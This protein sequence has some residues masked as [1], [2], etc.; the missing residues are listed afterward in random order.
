MTGYWLTDIDMQ[1][2]MHC[3]FDNGISNIMMYMMYMSC[4]ITKYNDV[5]ISYAWLMI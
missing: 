5:I 2:E 1:D 4:C 3:K